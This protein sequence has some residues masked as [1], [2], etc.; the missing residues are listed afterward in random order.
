MGVI[1]FFTRK[2]PT[3]GLGPIP[4]NQWTDSTSSPDV[5]T[6]ASTMEMTGVERYDPVRFYN[7]WGHYIG[8]FEA[9][10]DVRINTGSIS[11]CL[12]TFFGLTSIKT[13]IN[14]GVS[15]QTAHFCSILRK[16]VGGTRIIE[17]GTS[18]TGS[19]LADTW[20]YVTLIRTRVSYKAYVYSDPERTV[21]LHTET[22]DNS[23]RRNPHYWFGMHPK[24]DATLNDPIY[25]EVANLNFLSRQ[26]F[27]HGWNP[28]CSHI[29]GATD[30]SGDQTIL[31]ISGNDGEFVEYITGSTV[32]SV[33][34]SSYIASGVQDTRKKFYCEFKFIAE[35]GDGK[36]GIRVGVATEEYP[37]IGNVN[38]NLGNDESW[39]VQANGFARNG[40]VGDN[41][42]G[43]LPEFT[44]DGTNAD[45]VGMALDLTDLETGGG[46][47]WFHRN[48]V[49]GTTAAVGGGVGN[50]AT[51]V[52]ASC[53]ILNITQGGLYVPACSIT[54]PGG[55]IEI[56]GNYQDFTYSPPS[57]FAPFRWM[58][59]TT[60]Q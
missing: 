22:A 51:G 20:Y 31:K 48:G 47:I 28:N 32:D 55:K 59:N 39:C 50:P 1:A 19:L 60:Y 58:E 10:V 30:D 45:V 25:A 37:W 24:G 17:L 49:W 26:T 52:N 18:E 36:T 41:V 5:I 11:G 40:S 2:Q 38:H 46:K 35:P 6:T 8:T 16:S 4:L 15:D 12:W 21:L 42:T 34:Q 3:P 43:Y 7:H 13:T 53:E 14:D 33:A 9:Q 23:N 57:G 29:S 56:I 27:T 54:G 44:V